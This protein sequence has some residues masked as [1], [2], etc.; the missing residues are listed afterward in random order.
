MSA[1]RKIGGSLLTGEGLLP[2]IL[3]L[4]G[5]YWVEQAFHLRIWNGV[6]PG[7]G[8]M[9]FIYGSLL[10]LFAA[11]VLFFVG[12]DEPEAGHD[13][14][15]KPLLLLGLLI[16][17]VL[18]FPLIGAV[19]SLFVMMSVMYILVERLPVVRS[20]LIA[21]AVTATFYV[22]F[23]RWLSVSLPHGPWGF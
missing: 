17:T 5:A 3:V 20:L 1:L 18:G 10:I 6:Q 14:L 13:A 7:S 19:A 4:M 15:R 2:L 16:L 23:D 12:R 22:V 21:A 8:L 11:V 9:P